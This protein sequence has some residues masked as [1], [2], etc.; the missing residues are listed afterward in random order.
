[1]EINSSKYAHLLEN[2]ILPPVVPQLNGDITSGLDFFV[3]RSVYRSG[4]LFGKERVQHPP[5]TPPEVD[6]D[7]IKANVNCQQ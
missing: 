3:Q 4:R 2:S 5:A 1:M 6:V 7:G